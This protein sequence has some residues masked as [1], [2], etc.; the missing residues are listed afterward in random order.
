MLPWCLPPSFP[1]IQLTVCEQITIEDLKDIRRRCCLKI[2]KKADNFSNS[3][4]LCRSDASHQ[5]LAQ[6]DQWSERWEMSFEDFQD[7]SH[8][9][10]LKK[11]ILA[12][13]NLCVTVMLPIKFWLNQTY[14][15][16]GD[17][18]WRI[19]RW[20]P[21]RLS[22]ISEWNSFSNSESLYCSNASH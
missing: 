22:W 17:V 15:L 20:P 18:I 4:S 21:W 11:M 5:V 12:I 3:E 6:S 9:G 8:L 19:S 10:H 7:G 16:G 13:L 1:S 2:F 14:G